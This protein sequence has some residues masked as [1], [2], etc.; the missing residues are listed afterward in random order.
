MSKILLKSI[1]S[2]GKKKQASDKCDHILKK[3]DQFSHETG[4]GFVQELK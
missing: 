1:S 2:N 4:L 3:K